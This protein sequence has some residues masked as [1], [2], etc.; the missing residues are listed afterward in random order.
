MCELEVL[1][2]MKRLLFIF[3]LALVL[4]LVFIL[5][6]EAG[7]YWPDE[8]YY[9]SLARRVASGEGYGR[10]IVRGPLYTFFLA[11]IYQ[12]IHPGFLVV[13][14]LQTLLDSGSALLLVYLG[15]YFFNKKAG[16]IAGLLYAFYPYFIYLSGMLASESLYLFL[17]FLALTFYV[18]FRKTNQMRYL[19][20]FGVGLGLS[21]LCRPVAL[22]Y[23]FPFTLWVGFISFPT[24]NIMKNSTLFILFVFLPILPWTARNY[25]VHGKFI[26]ISAGSGW[27]LYLGNGPDSVL[28][29]DRLPEEINKIMLTVPFVDP[30]SLEPF[31]TEEARRFK[32]E[33]P[34]TPG[35]VDFSLERDALLR[36]KALSYI[37]ANP[38]R[39][40][41]N[42][43]KKLF[44]FWAPIKGTMSKNEF[45]TLTTDILGAVSFLG[46]FIPFLF[47]FLF[48]V[49]DWRKLFPLYLMIFVLNLGISLFTTTIRYR[50]G[51][52]PYLILFAA[53]AM[54]IV[55]RW[56]L[57]RRTVT[58]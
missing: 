33:H 41:K 32:Q 16:W 15:S 35:V 30:P 2:A 58:V 29:G 47:G 3:F 39:F 10:W 19:A 56:F 4:R 51:I 54:D 17:T 27:N 34:N 45:T 13:R 40:L 46:I 12:I 24:R 49:K 21:A 18:F 20:L 22:V 11:G 6:L 42:Y 38:F 48:S 36:E 26:L 55:W 25:M 28:N 31:Y 7:Y 5:T 52:D 9:D 8:I 14:F 43:F 23:L 1:N 44:L 57:Q 37:R 53:F 50:I